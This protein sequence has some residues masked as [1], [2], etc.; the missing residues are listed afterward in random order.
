MLDT[1]KSNIAEKTVDKTLTEDEKEFNNEFIPFETIKMVLTN[2]T[3]ADQLLKMSDL[4]VTKF[5]K[6]WQMLF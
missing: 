3:W 5:S 1:V 2:D 6:I 4:K